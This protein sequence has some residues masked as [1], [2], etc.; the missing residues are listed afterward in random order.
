MADVHGYVRMTIFMET[1]TLGSASELRLVRILAGLQAGILSGFVAL[2]WLLLV[3]FV[4]FYSFWQIPNVFAA[5][6]Y[7]ARSIRPDF[8]FYTCSGIAIHLLWFGLA[9]MIFAWGV[10]ET[11]SWRKSVIFALI[12]VVLLQAVSTSLIWKNFNPWL[13]IYVSSAA[14]WLASIMVGIGISIIPF[15][16]RSMRRDFLLK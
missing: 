7:G 2:F 4:S 12:Y 3:S 13:M 11:L 5:I 6:F 15:L 10:P 14:L 9:G 16:I 1:R 8:G